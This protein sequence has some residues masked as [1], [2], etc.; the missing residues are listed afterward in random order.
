MT[1][2]QMKRI[3]V[4]SGLAMLAGLLLFI[5]ACVSGAPPTAESTRLE[6]AGTED[7]ASP[8]VTANECE[9][10]LDMTSSAPAYVQIEFNGLRYASYF[11]SVHAQEFS[12]QRVF[13]GSTAAVYITDFPGDSGYYNKVCRDGTIERNVPQTEWPNYANSATRRAERSMAVEVSVRIDDRP[14][15]V[16]DARRF[17]DCARLCIYEF[18]IPPDLPPGDY[19]LTVSYGEDTAAKFPIRV[20]A[21]TPAP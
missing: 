3:L 12:P 1:N 5:G 13:P 19:A 10:V 20:I 7:P 8:A 4:F 15:L 17:N 21:D 16:S 2:L 14:I 11:S 9:L 18:A 6:G